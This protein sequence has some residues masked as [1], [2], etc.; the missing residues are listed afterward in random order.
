VWTKLEPWRRK[1]SIELI[2]ELEK[3]FEVQSLA[4]KLHLPYKLISRKWE[5]RQQ[6]ISV[7]APQLKPITG[8][9][10]STMTLIR[11]FREKQEGKSWTHWIGRT[12]R[13]SMCRTSKCKMESFK[14]NN[15]WDTF[16][17]T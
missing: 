5:V 2:A 14:R 11:R 1:D 8:C 10:A 12:Q 9:K 3:I 4:E 13:R 7:L 17:G 16:W 6:L 15:S